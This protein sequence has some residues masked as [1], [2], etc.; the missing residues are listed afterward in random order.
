MDVAGRRVAERANVLLAEH[1]LTR[2]VLMVGP[3]HNCGDAQVAAGH[4]SRPAE[5]WSPLR[6]EPAPVL[7]GSTLVIDGLF[8]V[9]LCRP[10]T[11]AARAAIE[12]VNASD[13]MV[14]AIDVPS[15]LSADTGE[16]VGADTAEG[17]V[18][19]CADHTVTFVGPKQGFFGREGP[20][21]VGSWTAV[22]IGFPIEEAEEWVRH[23]RSRA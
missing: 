21:S 4:L 15:G 22:D 16:I 17:G 7:D 3:G 11:G 12:A 19:V 18:A 1:G 14:L 9:G 2:V 13:A 8:G 23:R 10:V 5:L 6:D 20:A